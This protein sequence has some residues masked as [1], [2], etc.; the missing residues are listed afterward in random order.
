MNRL[1]RR[2]IAL[3]ICC[4]ILVSNILPAHARTEDVASMVD[5][6]SG[7]EGHFVLLPEARLFVITAQRPEDA[8]VETLQLIS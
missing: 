6:Y 8:L 3:L 4:M 7:E 1:G 2:T 5:R